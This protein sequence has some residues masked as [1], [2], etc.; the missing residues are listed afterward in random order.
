MPIALFGALG[1]VVWSGGGAPSGT[2]GYIDLAACLP[3]I[4]GALVAAPLGV[5]LAHR[6]D[7]VRLKKAFG[8]LLVF[9]SLRMLYSAFV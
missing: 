7:A 9:V 6:T 2:L 1:Y 5:K 4:A 8:V 3:I